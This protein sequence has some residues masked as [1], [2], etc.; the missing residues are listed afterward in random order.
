M[1]FILWIV[2]V[3]VIGFIAAGFYFKNTGDPKSE[4]IIGVGVLIFA[5][6]LMPLFIYHRSKGKDISDYMFKGPKKD[7]EK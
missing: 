6:I 2:F 3:V 7:P 4:A 5:F 1:R